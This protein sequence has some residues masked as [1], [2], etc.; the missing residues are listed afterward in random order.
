MPIDEADECSVHTSASSC[1]MA[2]QAGG[3]CGWC[4]AAATCR[5]GDVRGPCARGNCQA[6]PE[7]CGLW[8]TPV[9]RVYPDV[10]GAPRPGRSG[11]GGNATSAV[12]VAAGAPVAAAGGAAGGAGGAAGGS[13]GGWLDMPM[14]V[15]PSLIAE[16]SALHHLAAFALRELQRSGCA[17]SG[18]TEGSAGCAVLR[19]A[20]LARLAAASTLVRPSPH[21]NP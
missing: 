13:A 16:G 6:P 1:L 17:A 4:Q 10:G 8:H 2:A 15:P 5:R 14:S 7:G 3:R 21:P 20:R 12:A 9:A 18:A 19:D 11:G